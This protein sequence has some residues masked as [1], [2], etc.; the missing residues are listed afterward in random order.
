MQGLQGPAAA[1]FSLLCLPWACPMGGGNAMPLFSTMGATH[2][3]SLINLLKSY[4]PMGVVLGATLEHLILLVCCRMPVSIRP[5]TGSIRLNDCAESRMLCPFC[6]RFFAWFHWATGPHMPLTCF[7]SNSSYDYVYECPSKGVG[8]SVWKAF[9]NFIRE[10]S[11]GNSP[12]VQHVICS[13]KSQ[14]HHIFLFHILWPTF[15]FYIRIAGK[16]G[17]RK[18]VCGCNW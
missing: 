10:S 17:N 3:T 11:T 6:M 12:L 4:W 2:I 8:G 14:R 13:H 7:C 18:H 1:G 9:K 16:V 15:F 5:Y